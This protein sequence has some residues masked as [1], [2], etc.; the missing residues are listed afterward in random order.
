MLKNK[1]ALV[2]SVLCAIASVGFV[3]SASAENV[4]HGNLDEIVVEGSKDVLP[5][6]NVRT[7]AK[8]GVLG[9][10]SVMDI[11]YSE[12]SMTAKAVETY[13]DPS[14][15]LANVLMNNPSIRTST[16]SPMYTDFSM[17]GINMNGNHMML[18]G[19]PSLFYQFTTPPS[20]VIDRIDITSG[21]NAGVNGVSM[22]NNGTNSGATPAPGTINI[23]TKRALNTPVNRYTQTFSGRGNAGEFIDVGRRFG[24]NNE[25][26]IRVNAEYMEG[27]LALPGAEKNEKNIFI[28]MD[29][30]GD[31]NITNLFAAYF[32]L[33][34]NGGQRWFSLPNSYSSTVLPDAPDSKNNY[35]FNGTTKYVHGYLATLNHEHKL[36]DT[37]SYFANMGYSRRSGN[38]DNQGA[39][40]KFDEH[41]NFV[42]NQFNQQ[43]EEGKNAYVQ[44][45]LKGNLETGAVK[46]DL[47]LSVDRSWARYWNK[48]KSYKPNGQEILGNL[49][50]G[51]IF[52]DNYVLQSFGDGTPQWEETNIGLTIAD[53]I[54]YGKASMLLAASRKHEN[55]ESFTGKSFK[56]DN[57]LP[58][59]GLTYKPV[60]NMAFYYG[61]T[62]SFSRGLVVSGNNY[63]NNGETMGPVKSKQ[64]EIGVKYQNAGMMTTLSY[65][66]IDE[67]NRYDI[68]SNDPNHPLTKVDDGK[69]RYKGVELTVNGK[70]ADKWTVTGGLL[71][72]DAEREKTK[73]GTK[74]GWFVNGASEWSGVLGLEYKPDD[75]LGIVG[76]AV[77]NDKAYIDSRSSSGKTEIPSY[78]TFDVGV[79]YKTKINTVPVKLSAMCYNVA[80]KDYWMG[81]GSS[82]TIGLS[83]PRTF[84]LSAQFDI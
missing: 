6:G 25:W 64:N 47:A 83:M 46:H 32:D 33:R 16:T 7:T 31:N 60:E 22:S 81:R 84:M 43:N 40:I 30:R 3:M 36:D 56:N 13:G 24:E 74:D 19:V 2:M 55:F 28:N 23:V 17:R 62:E 10:K 9:D 57:I 8:L 82:T 45:G 59:Y 75:S 21:P 79:N 70:L 29:H 58:T 69:N 44:F 18:N 38:K 76:R 20:H 37:W 39:S 48:S 1:K 53:T 71:Y 63:T 34:V 80:D 73:N 78:V 14:Q 50:D 41:G 42:G 68:N 26:G 54:S 52:P 12:M 61:H 66:D 51:I 77:W 5:G 65:F 49:Y 15:P 72:L 11:P 4:V 35:D 67:A 27:G